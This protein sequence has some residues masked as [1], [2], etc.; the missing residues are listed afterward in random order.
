MNKINNLT[1][2]N[3]YCLYKND[4]RI[5]SFDEF[6]KAY[7]KAC[8]YFNPPKNWFGQKIEYSP[9]ETIEIKVVPTLVK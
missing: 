4:N 9:G 8:E 7:F 5:A 2:K 6:N 1:Y 3:K